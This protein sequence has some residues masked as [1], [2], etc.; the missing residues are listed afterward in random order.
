[1]LARSND[2]VRKWVKKGNP[3]LHFFSPAHIERS[4]DVFP[5]EFLDMM[6]RHKVL[7]GHD[8]LTDIKVDLKNLRHQCESELKGKLLHLRAFYA[9]NCHRP[10]LVARM[11]VESFSTFLAAFR[12]VLRLQNE[13]PPSDARATIEKAAIDVGFNPEIFLEIIEIRRGESVLPRRD[14]ALSAFEQYLTEI[15]AITTYVDEMVVTGD[16]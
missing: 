12:A 15:E 7:I 8:P 3:P 2:V 5:I 1:M 16:Q 13:E 10:K 6:A 11:M 14:A 9:A 4:L